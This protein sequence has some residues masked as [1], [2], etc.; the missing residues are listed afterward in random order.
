[1]ALGLLTKD[2][3]DPTETAALENFHRDR[4]PGTDSI[5][6]RKRPGEPMGSEL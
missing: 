5:I 2:L 3:T 4:T 6:R 1:M